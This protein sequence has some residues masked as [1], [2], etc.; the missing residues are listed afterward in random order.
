MWGDSLVDQG[1]NRLRSRG[2]V[3]PQFESDAGAFQGITVSID[4]NGFIF[5]ARPPFQEGFEQFNRF[6]PERTDSLF[7]A[8]SL[9]SNMERGLPTKGSGERFNAS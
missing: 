9:Q 6:R 7:A 5:T 1:W 8:F 3:L 2:Y 4:E